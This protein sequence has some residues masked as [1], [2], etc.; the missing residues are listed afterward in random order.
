MHKEQRHLIIMLFLVYAFSSSF[1][2]IPGLT[3][4]LNMDLILKF[5]MKYQEVNET[6][7]WLLI[8]VNHSFL[9]EIDFCVLCSIMVLLS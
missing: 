2:A 3:L 5:C 7:V 8:A 9:I 6:M 4:D 1:F